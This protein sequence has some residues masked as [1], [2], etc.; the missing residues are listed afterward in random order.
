MILTVTLNAALDR[1]L[2]VPNISLAHQH[3]ATD[4]LMLPGGK[5]VNIARA[6]KRLGE[7]VIATGMA[8]GRIGTLIAEELTSE[9]I[10]NDF[11]RCQAESRTSVAIVDP[12]TLM[13]MEV[14]ESGPGVDAAEIE[15]FF[16]K[17]GYLAKAARL[18]V[19]AGSL[20]PGTPPDLYAVIIRELTRMG[21]PA[22]VDAAGEPLR[23]SLVARPLLISPNVREAEETVGYEFDESGPQGAD[24]EALIEMGAKGAIIHFPTGAVARFK[25]DPNTYRATMDGPVDVISTVGSGDSFLAG[26]L[27]AWEV[28]KNPEEALRKGVACGMAN[29]TTLGAG[30]FDPGDIAAF[31]SRVEV[32]TGSLT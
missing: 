13:Q 17:L 1:T 14:N 2:V 12:M 7:P 31:A 22:V 3:R 19:L 5:G 18:V 10:L 30:M 27:S 20:P 15:T 23:A 29:A 21:C 26:F 16:E 25:G 4:S 11:V 28:D 24:V 9:G 32:V 8:G 6:L